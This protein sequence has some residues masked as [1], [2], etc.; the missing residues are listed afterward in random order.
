M[1]NE[2]YITVFSASGSIIYAGKSNQAELSIDM[3]KQASG[4]YIV[5]VISADTLHTNKLIKQ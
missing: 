5:R 2:C 1:K 3:T 4:I